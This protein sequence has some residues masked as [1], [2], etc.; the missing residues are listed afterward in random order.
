MHEYLIFIVYKYIFSKCLN[1]NTTL[2]L[3]LGKE[4]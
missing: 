3:S 2:T 4:S 1:K